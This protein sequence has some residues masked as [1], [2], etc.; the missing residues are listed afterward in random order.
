MRLKRNYATEY[1]TAIQAAD[2]WRDRYLEALAQY[3]ATDRT[4]WDQEAWLSVWAAQRELEDA[5]RT[6]A[7]AR[8][9]MLRKRA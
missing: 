5:E 3:A 7:V 4:T 2:Y 1:A 9:A 8:R 6:F